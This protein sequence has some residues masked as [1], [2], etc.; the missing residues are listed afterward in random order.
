VTP[1]LGKKVTVMAKLDGDTI[2][3]AFAQAAKE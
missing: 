2:D 3:I 1:L